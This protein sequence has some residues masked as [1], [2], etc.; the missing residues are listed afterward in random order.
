MNL[1]IHGGGRIVKRLPK[2][3]LFKERVLT[4]DLFP[5]TVGSQ[6]LQDSSH[7]DSHSTNARLASALA[8]F[9]GDAVKRWILSHR[10]QFTRFPT[11]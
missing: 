3:F 11:Q 8:G 2:I 6:N 1:V 5:I 9:D 10:F 7:G 4:K